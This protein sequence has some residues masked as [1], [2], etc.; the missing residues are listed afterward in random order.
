[1]SDRLSTLFLETR[2]LHQ[3]DFS[4][5]L[6]RVHQNTIRLFVSHNFRRSVQITCVYLFHELPPAARQNVINEAARHLKPGGIFVWTDSL[7]V[8]CGNNS[9]DRVENG[10]LARAFIKSQPRI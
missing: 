4:S 2:S 8:G 9:P 5:C 1:M 6:S 10:L 3:V 7:H